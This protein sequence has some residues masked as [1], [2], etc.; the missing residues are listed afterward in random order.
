MSKENYIISVKNMVCPRCI[1]AV[2]N[3]LKDLS[4][5]YLQVDL[6]IIRLEKE[7][8]PKQFESLKKAVEDIGFEILEH[9]EDK[10]VEHIKTLIIN[11]IY[12]KEIQEDFVLSSYIN[13]HIHQTYS[14]LSKIFSEKTGKTIEQY[15]ILQ[16][17]EKAKELLSL[18]EKNI[19][20]IAYS[21]GY[22]HISHFSNQFKSIT[23]FSPSVYQKN[24]D[25]NRSSIDQV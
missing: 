4:I 11:L 21:L 9:I 7:L 16:K 2:E 15:F 24:Q 14:Y 25:N 3:I 10:H 17:I 12:N 8:L 23:G 20:E 19:S 6:G 18:K 5:D 13:K 22:V 1:L